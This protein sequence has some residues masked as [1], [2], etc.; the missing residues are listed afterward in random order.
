MHRFKLRVPHYAI[1]PSG[2]WP[3]KSI[4]TL[5]SILQIMY[6]KLVASLYLLFSNLSIMLLLYASYL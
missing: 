6:V 2:C 4:Y 1:N 5:E 3:L